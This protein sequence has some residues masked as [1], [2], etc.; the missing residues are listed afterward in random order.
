MARERTHSHPVFRHGEPR[1]IKD[2]NAS[3]IARCGNGDRH[4]STLE[5]NHPSMV[6][7]L[8]GAES[9]T[10]LQLHNHEAMREYKQ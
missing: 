7:H 3:P 2:G 6:N 1:H 8:K 9:V 5:N 10:P 4:G